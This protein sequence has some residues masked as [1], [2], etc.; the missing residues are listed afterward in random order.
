MYETRKANKLFVCLCIFY[1]FYNGVVYITI[2]I[3]KIVI[4]QIIVI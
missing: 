3:K 1:I 2:I 4:F